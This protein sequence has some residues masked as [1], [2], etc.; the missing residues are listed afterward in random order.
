MSFIEEYKDN[1]FNCSQNSCLAH[2]VSQDYEMG[3]GIAVIFKKIF[4][5]VS[6]LQAQN[7]QVGE[8]SI[9][10]YQDRYIYYLVTK[11]KYW[12]KPTY[13]TLQSS[14][15]DMKK[16]AIENNI[17]VISIPQIGCGLDK[18]KWTQVKEILVKVFEETGIKIHVYSI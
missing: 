18:L 8:C 17:K 12:H 1:L 2:C 3:K 16:H 6:E 14:L 13:E 10:S 15:I 11:E 5:R 7:K 9:L 4:G